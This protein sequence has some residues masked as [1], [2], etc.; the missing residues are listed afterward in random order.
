MENANPSR[1]TSRIRRR[2]IIESEKVSLFRPWS[3]RSATVEFDV[4][5]RN[6]QASQRAPNKPLNIDQTGCASNRNG[7]A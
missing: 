1:R 7:T 6:L 2:P 5:R 4:T 3:Q